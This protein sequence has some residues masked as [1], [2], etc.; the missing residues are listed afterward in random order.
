MIDKKQVRDKALVAVMQHLGF[1]CE[2]NRNGSFEVHA[3]D[4][5]FSSAYQKFSVH[6]RPVFLRLRRL[7]R[8]PKVSN[9]L[10][11]S[12][13]ASHSEN[14]VVCTPKVLIPIKD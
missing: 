10:M 4:V 14:L 8:K 12:I 11:N 2:L 7:E 1:A 9:Q 3:S 5:E 6:Y 13:G